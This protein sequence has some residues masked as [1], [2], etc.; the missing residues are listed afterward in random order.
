[1]FLTFQKAQISFSLKRRLKNCH[2]II[3]LLFYK[4]NLNKNTEL[5]INKKQ[6]PFK[7]IFISFE[8]LEDLWF[9][10]SIKFLPIY[11]WESCF[12]FAC[13]VFHN[14]QNLNVN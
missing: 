9:F 12:W 5:M 6:R 14:L 11:G 2:M 1:M 13:F 4:I 10:Q 7:F 8:I 3:N